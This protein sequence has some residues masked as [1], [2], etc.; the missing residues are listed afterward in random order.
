LHSGWYMAAIAGV[1]CTSKSSSESVLDTKTGTYAAV[2]ADEFGGGQRLREIEVDLDDPKSLGLATERLNQTGD[3]VGSTARSTRGP[4]GTS[5]GNVGTIP[6][7]IA[8]DRQDATCSAQEL[9][10]GRKLFSRERVAS[11]REAAAHEQVQEGQR[12]WDIAVILP[13]PPPNPQH[14]ADCFVFAFPSTTANPAL[15][16]VRDYLGGLYDRH[17]TLDGRVDPEADAGAAAEA[18]AE[19]PAAEVK[20]RLSLWGAECGNN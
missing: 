18:Q 20:R 7:A 12:S 17:W 11:D 9:S 8:V 6:G 2:S 10:A 15:R 4:S 5:P 19:P 16:E 1:C 14:R 13:K 3:Q